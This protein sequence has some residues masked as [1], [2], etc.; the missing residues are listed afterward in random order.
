MTLRGVPLRLGTAINGPAAYAYGDLHDVWIVMGGEITPA[1]QAEAAHL[2]AQVWTYSY[3]ILREEYLP[4]RQRYYAGLYTWTHRLGGNFVWAYSHV[5]HGHAW[6]MPGTEEPLPITGWEG[7]R[8]GVDDYCYLQMVEDSAS[9]AEGDP[10]AVE[11][12]AW[13]A[14]LRA[15]LAHID[16]HEVEA[17]TPLSLAEYD[18]IRSRAAGY[19]EQLGT[20]SQERIARP[21][22]THLVD[23]A[24]AFRGQPLQTCIAGLDDVDVSRRRGAALALFEMGQQAAPAT[25][26]LIRALRM[27]PAGLFVMLIVNFFL[28][29]NQPGEQGL[30][31]GR[32]AGDIYVDGN[33]FIN[34]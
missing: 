23:Q 15:R 21:P 32:A 12:A 5:R 27:I 16:P 8:E 10:V 2:G 14:A 9:Q 1:M 34:P 33:V 20:P 19:I 26:A 29:F 17:G 18:E 22:V 3:R 25:G 13:L 24:A 31:S 4:L 11:A 30:R 6:W 7:R 28:K